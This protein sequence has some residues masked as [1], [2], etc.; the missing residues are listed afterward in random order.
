M[1]AATLSYSQALRAIGQNLTPL[2]AGGF[3]LVKW[4]N[5][6]VVW[7][8]AKK[9]FFNKFVEKIFGSADP[10]KKNPEH[11]YFS[12]LDILTWEIEQQKKRSTGS[13]TDSRDFSCVCRVVVNYLD[14]KRALEFTISVDADAIKVRYDRQEESFTSQDLYDLG[15]QMYLKRSS[16]GS[17]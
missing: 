11:L 15:I 7:L 17:T 1:A 3:E 6:Y 2:G 13:P 8:S 9:T 10:E 12:D 14:S 5:D 4:G 16:R